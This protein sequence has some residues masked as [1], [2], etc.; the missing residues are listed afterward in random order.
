MVVVSFR[1]HAMEYK[2]DETDVPK[3]KK[4]EL[5]RSAFL[6]STSHL[7]PKAGV[8]VTIPTDDSRVE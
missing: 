8:K 1:V 5:A 6:A 4:V 3:E 7:F 2:A